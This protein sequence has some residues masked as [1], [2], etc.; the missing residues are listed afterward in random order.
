MKENSKCK[1]NFCFGFC[2]LLKQ[3]LSKKKMISRSL[4]SNMEK[5]LVAQVER[6]LWSR[7]GSNPAPFG[8]RGYPARLGMD[9]CAM[10]VVS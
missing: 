3:R 8:Q 2:S 4:L 9:V 5:L 7:Q 1:Q 10:Q 6:L